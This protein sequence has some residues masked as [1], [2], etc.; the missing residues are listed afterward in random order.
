M[1]EV[2]GK[3]SNNGG[4]KAI[5]DTFAIVKSRGEYNECLVLIYSVVLVLL[6]T[7]TA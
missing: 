5:G 1:Q 7:A 3:K 6:V 4:K 2:E